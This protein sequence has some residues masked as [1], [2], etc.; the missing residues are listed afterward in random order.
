TDIIFPYTVGTSR[1][2]GLWPLKYPGKT[3]RGLPFL[4]IISVCSSLHKFSYTH[5]F[6]PTVIGYFQNC[7]KRPINPVPLST[8]RLLSPGYPK[9]A[10]APPIHSFPG[11][12]SRFPPVLLPLPDLSY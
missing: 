1:N 4:C 11:Y 12:P 8:Q 6:P 2:R 7:I 10:A 5:I 3:S 9:S